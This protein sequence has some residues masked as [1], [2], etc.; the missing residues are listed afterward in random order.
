M[1][2]L[3]RNEHVMG[4]WRHLARLL[5]VSD[6]VIDEI[7]FR[8]KENLSE[9]VYQSLKQWQSKQGQGATKPILIKALRTLD[10]NAAA[11]K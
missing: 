2:A 5:G 1:M 4:E 11:G 6:A 10:L 9:C 3:S 7:W 8:P